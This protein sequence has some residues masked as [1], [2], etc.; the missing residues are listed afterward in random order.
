MQALKRQ[1]RQTYQ[2]LLRRIEELE[3]EKKTLRGDPYYRML[4]RIYSLRGMA[5]DVEY[6]L[7]Q[8]KKSEQRY[9]WGEKEAPGQA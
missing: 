1:Y 9:G 3:Q 2:T 4:E 6:A 8:L 7:Y 5:N